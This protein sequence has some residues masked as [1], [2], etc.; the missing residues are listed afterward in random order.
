M[1]CKELAV[2]GQFPIPAAHRALPSHVLPD[3]PSHFGMWWHTS[4]SDSRHIHSI[5]LSPYDQLLAIGEEDGKTT[6]N[7][8]SW[9]T[10][11]RISCQLANTETLLRILIAL[12]YK[13][14]QQVELS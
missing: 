9:V 5:A 4:G 13:Q 6:I 1:R 12:G 2:C 3:V 10:V 8:L 11:V 7:G 14:S